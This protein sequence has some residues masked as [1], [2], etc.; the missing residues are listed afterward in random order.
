M[1]YE[2]KEYA[3]FTSRVLEQH[4]E[5]IERARLSPAIYQELIPKKFDLR[6]TVVGKKIFAV[7]IDS[8]S[9]PAAAIDWRRTENPKLPHHPIV[10]PTKL[11]DQLLILMDSLRLTFAG[12]DMILSESGEYVFLE[13]NPS[14]QWLWLDE[15]LGCGI[16]D[17]I[18]K[19][20]GEAEQS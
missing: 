11:S 13:V 9:D 18:A 16:S 6:V 20:L 3:I 1:V 15:M 2:G 8:Q 5:E 7:A 4:L 19:W 10:L 17:A 14:G 12:I